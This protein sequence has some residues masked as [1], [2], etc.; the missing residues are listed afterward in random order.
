MSFLAPRCSETKDTLRQ[1]R[2]IDTNQNCTVRL[3]DGST[4]GVVYTAHPTTALSSEVASTMQ[5]NVY[6]GSIEDPFVVEIQRGTSVYSQVKDHLKHHIES[7]A[8]KRKAESDKESPEVA[9]MDRMIMISM[10]EATKGYNITDSFGCFHP[11]ASYRFCLP[12][13]L[14]PRSAGDWGQLESDQLRV[15]WTSVS[16]IRDFLDGFCDEGEESKEAIQLKAELEKM[17]SDI[18]RAYGVKVREERYPTIDSI[19]SSSSTPLDGYYQHP[20]FK[21]CAMIDKYA[22][23]ESAVDMFLTLL[24]WRLN[25]FSDWLYVLPQCRLP[26]MYD[27][28][29]GTPFKNWAIPDFVI[30]DVGSFFR[31]FIVEDKSSDNRNVVSNYQM[32]GQGIAA[33]QQ[34]V[35]N[36][37]S[38]VP[39]G[40]KKA[41]T[42]YSSSASSSSSSTSSSSPNPF[43][44]T[45]DGPLFG[46]R[47]NGLR[48]H[49]YLIPI[50]EAVTKAMSLRRVATADT[51]VREF[52]N[53]G[54][55]LDFTQKEDRDK[56][57]KL[58]DRMCLKIKQMG[59]ESRRRNSNGTKK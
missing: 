20:I 36:D 18:I 30:F 44:A 34:N 24:L 37:G 11:G 27:E 41:K 31:M 49:F 2:W 39:S 17:T 40:F 4:C 46:L 5:I 22:T 9:A 50:G 58:L 3:P 8:K 19:S 13:R 53:K 59:Q 12:P 54:E 10:S 25:Y 7:S 33:H 56:I 43:A 14:I 15:K 26:L 57:I 38:Y 1:E 48:F 6:F 23:N 51:P 28:Q 42:E 55:G 21:A 47:V 35:F 45:D 32:L 29:T 52:N 16:T